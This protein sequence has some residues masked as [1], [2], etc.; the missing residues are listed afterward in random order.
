M[1]SG[2]KSK[3]TRRDLSVSVN[4]FKHC[5]HFLF[6][7]AFSDFSALASVTSYGHLDG[8]NKIQRFCNAVISGQSM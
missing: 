8:Q 2:V 4:K 7:T 5:L 3:A 6:H 1:A